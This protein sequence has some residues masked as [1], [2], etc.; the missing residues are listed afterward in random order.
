MTPEYPYPYVIVD[1]MVGDVYE[2]EFILFC[3][4]FIIFWICR[5]N[6]LAQMKASEK[7]CTPGVTLI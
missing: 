7:G 1:G 2:P 5:S 3:T 4:D 6:I